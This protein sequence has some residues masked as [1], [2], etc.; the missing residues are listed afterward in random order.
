MNLLFALFVS[1]LLS[2]FFT[3]PAEAD[4]YLVPAY[5]G[6]SAQDF[7][8]SDDGQKY[9]L[10]GSGGTY[11]ISTNAGLSW[12]QKSAP[13]QIDSFEISMNNSGN[14]LALIDTDDENYLYI[15]RD[16][17]KNWI[18]QVSMGAKYWTSIDMSNDGQTIVAGTSTDDYIYLSVDYGQTWKRVLGAG[19]DHWGFVLS[20]SDGSRLIAG[21][22]SR[23][24]GLAKSSDGGESWVWENSISEG[25]AG[26]EYYSFSPDGDGIVL[27][28]GNGVT[29]FSSNFGASWK[30][31]EAERVEFLP[32][33][34]VL[35]SIDGDENLHVSNS[36]GDTWESISRP[37][38]KFDEFSSIKILGQ[39]V[40][41]LTDNGSLN[42]SL[43]FGKS[44]TQL[45]RG[46]REWDFPVLDSKGRLLGLVGNGFV[47]TQQ[48]GG[49]FQVVEQNLEGMKGDGGIWMNYGFD[50]SSD[51]KRIVAD[52]N[53]NP[54]ISKNSGRSWQ[55]ISTKS[56]G[57]STPSFTLVGSKEIIGCADKGIFRSM[58]NGDSWTRIKIPSGIKGIPSQYE[59]CGSIAISKNGTKLALGGPG[60]NYIW[61]SKDSGKKWSPVK[62]LGKRMWRLNASEN[63]NLLTACGYKN[64]GQIL[65]I[66][67]YS[68]N[69][70]KSWKKQPV[71][72]HDFV[73]KISDDGKKILALESKYD[74]WN[75][76]WIS[77][78]R[79]STWKKL[80]LVSFMRLFMSDDGSTL[81]IFK[82]GKAKRS[83]DNGSTWVDV[84]TD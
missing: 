19:R 43:D 71:R 2:G 41:L 33:S 39:K 57:D 7:E 82:D 15:S 44:W 10:V 45:T 77:T 83:T 22:D 69:W 42:T 65:A 3:S 9:L 56:M 70:G 66:C 79:G 46:S 55:R 75:Y 14:L 84:L 11:K 21:G 31:L 25:P 27:S 60:L 48:S 76:A 18:K 63:G 64:N 1:S 68:D 80:T 59:G 36:S 74:N 16:L 5:S 62:K 26:W 8:V 34:S 61:T 4:S 13:G 29:W 40:I 28:Q 78:D 20:S 54:V 30:S 23:H 49:L 73:T 52:R 72:K 32:D 81:M 38:Q 12:T 58:N 37:Y 6:L 17:G 35:F 50:T 47:A 24:N 53:G 51:G 67:H